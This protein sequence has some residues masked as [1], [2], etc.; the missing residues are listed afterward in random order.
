[1][2]GGDASC[3]DT[4]GRRLKSYCLPSPDW[5][6]CPV[7][8]LF[9]W[10]IEHG[11]LPDK[12]QPVRCSWG[13]QQDQLQQGFLTPALPSQMIFLS[14]GHHLWRQNKTVGK[15]FCLFPLASLSD[16]C[17]ISCP[18]PFAVL[19]ANLSTASFFSI[20]MDTSTWPRIHSAL[21]TTSIP[22]N[23]CSIQYHL[24]GFVL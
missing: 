8:T 11:E 10:G 12:S 16:L 1:M 22:W 6:V 20:K 7:A 4:T 5:E 9:P 3:A 13:L 14:L 21:H 23:T 2:V 24:L 15:A 19:G 17:T 18:H